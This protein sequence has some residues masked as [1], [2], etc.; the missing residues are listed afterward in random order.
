MV[1]IDYS[2]LMLK[3]KQSQ[4]K[5]CFLIKGQ[6]TSDV[7]VELSVILPRTPCHT[8]VIMFGTNWSTLLMC[9]QSQIQQFLQIQ[10]QITQTILVPLNH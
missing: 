8:F 7:T 10:G 2:L 3:C 9:K 4:I 6:I 1:L 5:Q